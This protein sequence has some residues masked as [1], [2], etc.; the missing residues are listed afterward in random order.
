[1]DCRKAEALIQMELDRALAGDDDRFSTTV[2]S[3]EMALLDD[4]IGGCP[5][6]A[7]LRRGFVAI[8]AAL[9]SAPIEKAPVWLA[10]AVMSEIAETSTARR[11]T[12]PLGLY[13]TVAVGVAGAVLVLVRSGTGQVAGRALGVLSNAL[14]SLLGS[15]QDAITSSAGF[16][17]AQASQM[18]DVAFGIL[19][20]LVAVSVASIAILGLR[21]ARE[22]THELQPISLH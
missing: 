15:A 12:V 17:T 2:D 8:D 6:C 4:H 7:A 16:Q 13:T 3:S 14:S 22:L 19:C 20:G 18:G 10:A 9:R 5:R 1:M 11:F 21:T